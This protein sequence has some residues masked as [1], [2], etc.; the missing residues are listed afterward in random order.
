MHSIES[1]SVVVQFGRKL[2]VN[3]RHVY[4]TKHLIKHMKK[5]HRPGMITNK[6]RQHSTQESEF[7]DFN[8]QRL[9]TPIRSNT[10]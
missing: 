4:R 5:N 8:D 1:D 10:G 7:S 3:T 6:Q 9:S 2:I